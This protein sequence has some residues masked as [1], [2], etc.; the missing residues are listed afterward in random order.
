[1]QKFQTRGGTVVFAPLTDEELAKDDFK[2]SIK[3]HDKVY[4]VCPDGLHRSQ[5][6]YL[7]MKGLKRILGVKEGVY[8]P[9]GALHGFD[10]LVYDDSPNSLKSVSTVVVSRLKSNYNITAISKPN[11]F[12]L[13]LSSTSTQKYRRH[14]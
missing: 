11:S 6:L 5:V 13:P 12:T 4:P 7:V 8:L 10:P 9:H 1:M 14:S 2:F 3:A